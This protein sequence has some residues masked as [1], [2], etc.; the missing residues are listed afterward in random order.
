MGDA[1]KSLFVA[2]G[3][4]RATLS[5]SLLLEQ[6]LFQLTIRQQTS[7]V[8]RSLVGTRPPLP[9]RRPCQGSGCSLRGC[10][11]R[12]LQQCWR[13]SIQ[14]LVATAMSVQNA[15][16]PGTLESVDKRSK[17]KYPPTQTPVASCD[18]AYSIPPQNLYTTRP[19]YARQTNACQFQPLAYSL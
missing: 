17:P 13:R 18:H 2:I 6:R 11:L 16:R 14:P 15:R 10:F 4:V 5:M 3:S 1:I 9:N 8:R 19:F 7:I 12:C